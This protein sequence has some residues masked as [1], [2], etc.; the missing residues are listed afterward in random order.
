MT[1]SENKSRLPE[2]QERFKL[3]RK[4]LH[5]TQVEYAKHL[6]IARA[7]IGFY[8]N[9][10]RIPDAL[11]LRDIAQRCE[12]STD[13]LLGVTDT[14]KTDNIEISKATG[15]TDAAIQMLA[16]C[17]SDEKETALKVINQ[18]IASGMPWS[19]AARL[20]L[21]LEARRSI[22]PNVTFDE[23]ADYA[24]SFSHLEDGRICLPPRETA[25]YLLGEMKNDFGD[26][27]NALINKE[28]ALNGN[29]PETRE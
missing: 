9:G 19:I 27:I 18:F 24:Y 1:E 7:T 26:F 2:F 29:D 22:V 21:Y 5:M 15:L 20:E 28:G 6:G 16:F 4:E 10:E 12:V 14:R 25:R 8:E 13:W 11:T 23:A 17:V 3:L